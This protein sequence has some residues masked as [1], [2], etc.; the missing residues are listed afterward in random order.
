MS[1]K[2]KNKGMRTLAVVLAVLL[3]LMAVAGVVA[4][5]S[6]W[7]TDWSKFQSNDEQEEQL[8][9]GESGEETAN[10]GGAIIGDGEG[11]GVKLMSAKIAP[12]SYADYGISPMAESAYQL[13]AT[14]TPDNATNKT[15]DWSVSFVNSDSEWA[16]G[17]T[18]TDYVTVTPTADGALTANV[19]CLEDFGEQINVTVTSRDNASAYAVC[20][21]DFA[22]RIEDIKIYG[23]YISMSGISVKSPNAVVTW[24][25][26]LDS[27]GN[28]CWFSIEYS[29]YT[30]DDFVSFETTR[31]LSLYSGRTESPNDDGIGFYVVDGA[32][33]YMSFESDTKIP[34]LSQYLVGG[35][36]HETLDKDAVNAWIYSHGDEDGYVY[37]LSFAA[38]IEGEYS[39]FSFEVPIRFTASSFK[40]AVQDIELDQLGVIV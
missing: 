17:K 32:P 27:T 22:K 23:H 24:M 29:D 13:T 28:D 7:F 3:I 38:T 12:E 25:G 10:N 20:T 5:F 8:P 6:D 35:I 39:S 26:N 30:I 19:E 21:V 1:Y 40:V 34:A 9:E 16:A 4:Y 36:H 2:T 37:L 11:N 15:V 18:V 31:I 14:I 33:L